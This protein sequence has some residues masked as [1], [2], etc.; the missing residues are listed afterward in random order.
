MDTTT[1]KKLWQETMRGFE[2]GEINILVGTQT[3]SKGFHFPRVTLVG[4]LWAD[5]N[6]HFPIYNATESTLQQLIQVAGRAGRNHEKSEVIVQAIGMHK[7]FD[8][9]NE[10]DY[11]SFYTN[12]IENRKLMGYPPCKRLVEIELKNG[13]EISIE[14]E[15]NT[16]AITL[17]NIFKKSG[18]HAD[19]LGPS[20]PP[21]SKIKNTHIRKI[22]IKCENILLVGSLFR[23]I[24]FEKYSSQ[25]FFTPNPLN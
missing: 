22:Y 24:N 18:L 4:I 17:I 7:I 23:A 21:I 1:K 8:Y 9:L 12:E 20:Q 11:L 15:A 5:L 19:V 3:I 14:R 13:N 2:S 10:I 25:V 16:L 6:L